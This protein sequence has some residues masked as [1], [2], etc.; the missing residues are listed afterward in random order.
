MEKPFLESR[1][2]ELQ[3]QGSFNYPHRKV[4]GIHGMFLSVSLCLSGS[5]CL[6]EFSFFEPQ[7]CGE[8]V[9]FSSWC[10]CS[11]GYV[12]HKEKLSLILRHVARGELF[13]SYWPLYWF[14]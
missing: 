6:C 4:F 2:F 13:V 11:S 14:L 8:K 1:L 12:Y 10:T 9:I 7:D 5:L 3:F